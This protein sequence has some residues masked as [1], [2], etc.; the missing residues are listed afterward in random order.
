MKKV[1]EVPN[2]SKLQQWIDSTFI[3]SSASDAEELQQSAVPFTQATLYYLPGPSEL[4]F[5][6]HHHTVDGVGVMLFW[7]S[8]LHALSA[9][10]THI[11][12]CEE[13][14]RLAPAMESVLGY[15]PEPTPAQA[16]E[17]KD[18]FMS[19]AGSIPG[20]GPVSK[21]G[22]CPPGHCV[23][24]QLSFSASQTDAIVRAC[25]VKGFSVTSAV[26]A[27]HVLTLAQHA[28]P[29]HKLSQYVTA[30][31]FNL[32]RF[33]PMPYNSSKYAVSVYYTPL[34]FKIDLP[35]SFG[36]IAHT[37]NEYY[38]TSYENNAHALQLK[39]TFTRVLVAA[40]QTPEFLAAPV[41]RDAL[42][43]SLGII[44]QYVNRTYGSLR[45]KDITMGI[46]VIMGTSMLHI[47]TFH[48]QLRLVY[49]YNNAFEE[50][51][52]IQMYLEKVHGILLKEL[53]L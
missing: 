29:R 16:E 2:E 53:L 7:D 39:G 31:Q 40:V 4:V 45:V 20:I 50:P 43:S 22:T 36:V 17:A 35:S 5:R 15:P 18:L 47:Y 38:K 26:Q 23:N 19:W 48:D 1:Y 49:S 30:N 37:L 28:D 34:P 10:Q 21:L 41:P 6:A 25:K 51:A 12:F 3:V 46:D 32:R 9:P 8:F 24:K 13:P 42:V 52:N 14:A 33:L 44:E 11:S 27:A